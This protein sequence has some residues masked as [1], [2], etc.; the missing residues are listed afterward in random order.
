MGYMHPTP[1]DEQ[2]CVDIDECDMFDNLCVF[3]RCENNV[4]GFQCICDDG[5]VL[6]KTGGNCTGIHRTNYAK[7]NFLIFL[8]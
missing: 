6:D 4:G 3:G 1:A 7:S 5:F 8:L 2:S